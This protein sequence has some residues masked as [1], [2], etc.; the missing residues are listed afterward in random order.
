MKA[1]T[2]ARLAQ[3]AGVKLAGKSVTSQEVKNLSL[4][5]LHE[6]TLTKYYEGR[7]GLI[8]A[9]AEMGTSEDLSKLATKCKPGVAY[10]ARDLQLKKARALPM[11]TGF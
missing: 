2:H 5:Y 10:G 1:K 6:K 3:Y 9:L 11:G 4:R 8:D 7:K